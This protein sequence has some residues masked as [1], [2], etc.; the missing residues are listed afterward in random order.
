M[1]T[2]NHSTNLILIIETYYFNIPIDGNVIYIFD[3]TYQL[4]A[5]ISEASISHCK[6]HKI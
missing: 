3:T 5:V 6:Q 4:G 1:K 2:E